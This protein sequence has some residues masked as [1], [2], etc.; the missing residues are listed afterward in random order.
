MK[1]VV[2]LAVLAALAIPASAAV[3]LQDNFDSYADQAAFEAAWPKTAATTGSSTLSTEQIHS[4]AYS[5]K[6]LTTGSGTL[7]QSNYRNFGV[8]ADGSDAQPLVADF[9]MYWVSGATRTFNAIRAYS[10]AGFG[11]GT[12]DQIC[13]IGAYN[14][15]TAP[16]EVFNGNKWQGRVAFGSGVGWFNLD[17]AGSP[18]RS[19]GWH[20]FS[21]VVKS[22]TVD[23][24]VDD[25]LGRSFSRGTITTFDTF[26]IGS[27]LSS[28][29]FAAYTDDL[30]IEQVPEPA[31]LALL[32]LGGLGLIRRR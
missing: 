7:T 25:V 3:I 29:G 18:N 30:N 6:T 4:A 32:A 15:V 23:F 16:G 27:G 22:S 2:T 19:E 24:L 14:A 10:G 12:L 31:S 1:H 5:V 11:Q 13:A 9:W 8:E 28:A 21:V 20:K 26:V 17:A